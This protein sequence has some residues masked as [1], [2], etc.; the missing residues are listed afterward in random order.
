[1]ADRI[2]SNNAL[3]GLQWGMHDAV[4][5]GDIVSDIPSKMVYVSSQSQ[6]SRFTNVVPVGT[7]AAT[8]G[9]GSMWQLN[10]SK[11]W[12]SV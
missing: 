12:V 4:I 1:M 10:A 8:Y 3:K 2:L 7:I 6:L 5:D 9:F 11:Q